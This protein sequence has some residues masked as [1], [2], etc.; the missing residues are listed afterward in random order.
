MLERHELGH[1][2]TGYPHELAG[3]PAPPPEPV[4]RRVLGMALKAH[5][6]HLTAVDHE[7]RTAAPW[8]LRALEQLVAEAN[9]AAPNR[10]KQSDGG[11]GDARHQAENGPNGPG[12]GRI[13]TRG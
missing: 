10:H 8:R 7:L 6:R 12:S 13:T 11:I 1:R 2:V 4:E 9:A 5:G 3:D